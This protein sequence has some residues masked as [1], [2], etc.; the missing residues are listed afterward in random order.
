MSASGSSGVNLSLSPDIVCLWVWGGG[1]LLHPFSPHPFTTLPLHPFSSLKAL[2][3]LPLSVHYLH[4]TPIST[5]NLFITPHVE[6][7]T[8]VKTLPCHKLCLRALKIIDLSWLYIFV[9][10]I[11]L[12]FLVCNA[13]YYKN[14]TFCLMC[15]EYMV[16]ATVGN[17]TSCCDETKMMVPNIDHTACGKLFVL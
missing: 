4:H 11:M 13:G 15:P 8:P 9:K 1:C 16:K 14:G 5:Y 10:Y 7:Q 12:F 3:L 6:R 17:S 2:S